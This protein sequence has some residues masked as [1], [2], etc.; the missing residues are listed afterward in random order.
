MF[1]VI[2]HPEED[3]NSTANN[4]LLETNLKLPILQVA[5]GNFSRLVL[6]SKQI[7]KLFHSSKDLY[8]YSTYFVIFMVRQIQEVNRKGLEDLELYQI[9]N[10]LVKDQGQLMRDF[11]TEEWVCKIPHTCIHGLRT[12]NEEINQ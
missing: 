10:S 2:L 9:K 5:V 11:S 4:M 1:H 7:Y 6:K 12:P 8:Y 3:A